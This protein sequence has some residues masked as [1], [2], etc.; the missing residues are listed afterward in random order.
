MHIVPQSNPPIDLFLSL[1]HVLQLGITSST[2]VMT[3]ATEALQNLTKQLKS[4][5]DDVSSLK[6]RQSKKKKKSH[7]RS[8][9]RERC[10]RSQ[11]RTTSN[12][13]RGGRRR[14]RSRSRAYSPH[15]SRSRSR[16]R[17][18]GRGP[19]DRASP[20]RS[21]SRA[22][23]PRSRSRAGHRHDSRSRSRSHSRSRSRCSR[24][25]TGLSRSRSRS[26]TH[27]PVSRRRDWADLPD[28][29]VPD[30]EERV[31]FGEPD[32]DVRGT[33]SAPPT[34][35][36]EVRD[37]TAAFL[38]QKCSK[39]LDST[40]RLTVR[41]AYALP[42]VPATK[43]AG[44]DAYMK[45]EVSANVKASD[46]ELKTIQTAVLDCM[47][48]LS[49]LVEADAK[50]DDI[51][52]KEAVDAAKAAIEL[53]GNANAK[54]NHLRRTKIIAQMNKALLPLTEEDDIFIDAAPNLFGSGFAQKSK[55]YVE[56]VRAMRDRLPSHKGS[57]SRPQFFRSVPPNS[58]GGYQYNQ[59]FK[60]G[61]SRGG[62][63]HPPQGQRTQWNKH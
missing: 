11:G 42:K 35:L 27:S 31:A 60:R 58:R 9:S 13:P 49:T 6:Q 29:Y 20:F 26:R 44:L 16:S 56:Q 4:L 2:L 28:E 36:V 54:I 18:Q 39:R 61:G 1:K 48:P 34:R 21:R 15:V 51:T 8:R 41:N 30:Y 62:F 46:T 23:P 40:D 10:H 7:R 59:K 12:S 47:A 45:P 3:D 24:G 53:V 33:K 43:S 57:G 55:E 50:G 14:S 19:R 25:G 63:R 32:K 22:S 5:Q 37:E 17:S 38:K 52:H